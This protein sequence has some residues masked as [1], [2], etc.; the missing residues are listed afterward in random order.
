ATAAATA[1]LVALRRRWPGLL[2]AWLSY[3]A[4]LA[5]N[6]GLVRTGDQLA[7]DRYS[8]IA[9]MGWTAVAAA[10]L[11]RLGGVARQW[12]PAAV[13]LVGLAV[14]AVAGLVALS[15]AQCRPWHDSAAL[16][17]HALAHGATDSPLAHNNMGVA[18]AA[19]GRYAKAVAQYA[20]ALRLDP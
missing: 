18:L 6:S 13:G 12:R 10:G 4:I 8:Y 15:W 17:S 9:T 1:G 11:G 2:A 20:E 19:Q 5:P 3:L 16:W 7:A 14:A